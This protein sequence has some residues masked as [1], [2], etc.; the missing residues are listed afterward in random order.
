MRINTK[1]RFVIFL[2]L[3]CSFVFLSTISVIKIYN[4]MRRSSLWKINKIEITG[5]KRI[6]EDEVLKIL[7]IP[8]HTSI[9]DLNLSRLENKLQSHRWIEKAVVKWHFPGVVS[10]TL[11]ERYPVA[12]LCCDECFYVDSTGWLFS[13][14]DRKKISHDDV[15]W[16]NFCP[17]SLLRSHREVVRQRQTS[18]SVHNDEIDSS[19]RSGLVNDEITS[20]LPQD[21]LSGFLDLI[22]ALKNNFAGSWKKAEISYSYSD[23]F[24]VNFEGIK[25]LVGTNN[26]AGNVLKLHYIMHKMGV[27]QNNADLR[28]IDV[29]YAR[30]AFIR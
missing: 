17:H 11:V 26:I 30:W 19:A 2:V 29:R 1:T 28:E 15:P 23:G 20:V 10:V 8:P 27:F 4:F 14:I 21:I 6:S 25:A 3:W 16:F 13:R 24:I 7:D 18:P 9:W 5:L 22:R 12:V